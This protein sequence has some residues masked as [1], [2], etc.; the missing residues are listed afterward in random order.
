[1]DIFIFTYANDADLLPLCISH[2][3]QHGNVILVDDSSNPAT[4]ESG[5]QALGAH[6]YVPSTFDR[7]GNLNGSAAIRGML[8]T[9]S[10]HGNDEWIM[11][12]DSDT[13]LFRPDLLISC[14]PAGVTL[15]GQARGHCDDID[16]NTPY[17]SV[18][19]AGML[20]RRDTIPAML[21]LLDR[22]DIVTRIDAGPGYSDHV[23]TI[24]HQMAGGRVEI[25]R[26]E[27]AQLINGVYRRVAIH[28]TA[29]HDHPLCLHSASV[30]VM[31]KADAYDTPAARTAATLAA[32]QQIAAEWAPAP[33]Q[34]TPGQTVGTA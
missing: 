9:Y 30:S 12:C 4:D 29:D 24:L 15:I 13:L 23:I 7:G 21:A 20:I 17:H 3:A 33:V 10:E 25:L 8:E 28:R 2:A 14:A 27:R 5:A 6:E 11:Q 18:N 1:M 26:H 22:P 34:E 31:A 32:M 16:A 19:G